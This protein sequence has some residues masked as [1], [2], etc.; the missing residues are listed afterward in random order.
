MPKRQKSKT[1]KNSKNPI[2]HDRKNGQYNPKD[3]F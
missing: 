3:I 1:K 2:K